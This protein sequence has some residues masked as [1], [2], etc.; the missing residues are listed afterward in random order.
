MTPEQSKVLYQIEQKL[1][2]MCASNTREHKEIK[3]DIQKI[4]EYQNDRSFECEK[5]FDERPKM[6][7]FMWVLGGMGGIVL[8]LSVIFGG[9]SL[10]NNKTIAAIS[11]ELQDHIAFSV[12]VYEEITG[13]KWGQ[14]AREELDEARK[15]Y[16]AIRDKA[17][18][19]E[20][21]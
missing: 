11:H 9:I 5:K 12:I 7:L 17:L 6:N 20:K 13:K 16:K 21:Q 14:A 1:N 8:T 15:N 2:D 18:A 10:S 19:K 4:E 3:D